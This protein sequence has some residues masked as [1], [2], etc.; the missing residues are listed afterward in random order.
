MHRPRR[1]HSIRVLGGALVV[2]MTIAAGIASQSCF[3]GIKA[4]FCER[5]DVICKPGQE[6]AANQAVCI[7][8]GGCGDGIVDPAKGE[9]CD[10]GNIVDGETDGSGVF[11]PDG[12]SHDC[13]SDQTCGNRILDKGE[14]CDLGSDNGSPTST[15]DIEC[16][17]VSRVCGNGQVDQDVGEEC[18][19]GPM[20]SAGCNSGMAGRFACKAARCGDGYTNMA[21]GERCDTGGVDTAQCNGR[22]CTL[23]T[24]GDQYVNLVAGEECDSGS[25]DT[26]ICNG[27]QAGSASCRGSR[28]G[29]G[30]INVAAGEQ[31]EKSTDC[32]S[33]KVCSSCRCM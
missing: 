5:F 29:D 11:V 1:K 4:N 32:V 33:P 21:A 20:D 9:V 14:E 24:C 15:C 8:I 23:P 28:C 2:G 25:A 19:P 7:D 10:D 27:N 3:L 13:K 6:C 16:H 30:H 31:C 18:D 17:L 12:C 22:L 26:W